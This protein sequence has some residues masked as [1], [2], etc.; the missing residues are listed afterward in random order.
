MGCSWIG[1]F[2]LVDVLFQATQGVI[3]ALTG[4]PNVG[5]DSLGAEVP[6]RLSDSVILEQHIGLFALAH[7]IRAYLLQQPVGMNSVVLELVD[8]AGVTFSMGELPQYAVLTNVVTES[9]QCFKAVLWQVDTRP[10]IDSI[11]ASTA[12][13]SQ[14]YATFAIQKACAPCVS[15]LLLNLQPN[16]LRRLNLA[17]LGISFGTP[18]PA[19]EGLVDQ[20]QIWGG[21]HWCAVGGDCRLLTGVAIGVHRNLLGCSM[22]VVY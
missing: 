19:F 14:S 11:T 21:S 1:G 4:M 22:N 8:S 2:G 15:D 13:P 16:C 18:D 6:S 12:N 7:Q 5:R 3:A 20:L 9:Q 10:V 17:A